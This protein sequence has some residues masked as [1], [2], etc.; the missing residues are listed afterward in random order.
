MIF[1]FFLGGGGGVKLYV[2]LYTQGKPTYQKI[3]S[4]K[5][6]HYLFSNSSFQ[7]QT[8]AV[9]NLLQ[10]LHKTIIC[11]ILLLVVRG[12]RRRPF[13]FIFFLALHNCFYSK[14]KKG[15]KKSKN[16]YM[17]LGSFYSTT[18]VIQ[19]IICNAMGVR[20]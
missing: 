10:T 16:I 9:C 11:S 20:L 13:S 5:G 6:N 14:F 2:V 17:Y 3:I 18:Q 8:N 1:F 19:A 7:Y 12:Q 15:N 4:R